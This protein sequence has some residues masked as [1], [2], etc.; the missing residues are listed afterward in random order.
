MAEQQ[1]AKSLH[2]I[3]ALLRV[4][5]EE[6]AVQ[7]TPKAEEREPRS[8][9]EELP[10][11]EGNDNGADELANKP[12]PELEVLLVPYQTDASFAFFADLIELGPAFSESPFVF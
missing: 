9:H 3:A 6:P 7:N 2:E 10:L 11:D 5:A 8:Q 12:E 1:T 4:P